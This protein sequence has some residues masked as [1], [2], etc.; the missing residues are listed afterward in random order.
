MVYLKRSFEEVK[1]GNMDHRL[2]FRRADKHMMHIQDSFNEMMVAVNER[3]DS[4]GGAP[5]GESV[6][7][8]SE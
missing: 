8:P 7:G 1:A 3:N 6:R 2:R 5:T 4:G